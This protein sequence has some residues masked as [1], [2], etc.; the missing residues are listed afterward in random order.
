MLLFV[1][2]LF[3]ACWK[4]AEC[5][6]LGNPTE[7]PQYFCQ[8]SSRASAVGLANILRGG[9]DSAPGPTARDSDGLPCEAPSAKPRRMFAYPWESR[10]DNDDLVDYY[11][12]Y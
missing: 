2:A 4:Q 11:K 6:D 9:T 5:H 1:F 3:A 12:V 7:I 8:K 10:G